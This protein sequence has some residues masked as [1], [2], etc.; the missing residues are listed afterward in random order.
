MKQISNKT[1]AILLCT[2]LIISLFGTTITLVQLKKIQFPFITGLPTGIV[3]VTIASLVSISLPNSLVN[4]GNGSLTVTP[5]TYLN[6]TAAVNPSTF[7]EPGDLQVQNDGNGNVNVT[8]NGSP[9]G[10][11]SWIPGGSIYQW[12]GRNATSR[13][14]CL[15]NSSVKQVVQAQIATVNATM[16]VVCENL[17]FPDTADQVNV[18]IFLAIPANLT[19]GTYSD[20][21]VLIQAVAVS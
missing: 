20:N 2:A 13:N 11:A 7:N 10:T 21:S 18:S 8:M 3:N 19:P 4:F 6:T 9:V 17:T 12:Q 16:Q 15:T 14:G 1:L 5:L